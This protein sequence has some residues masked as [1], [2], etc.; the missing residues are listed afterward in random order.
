MDTIW[1][2]CGISVIL[3]LSTNI[4]TYLAVYALQG[5]TV[6]VGDFMFR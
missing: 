4:M 3:T 2:C 5:S 1:C 6:P